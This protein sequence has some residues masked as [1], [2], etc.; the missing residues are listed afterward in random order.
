MTPIRVLIVEDS[1]FMRKMITE[2]LSNDHRIQ[3]LGTARN[4]E[5]GLKKIKLLS[6]DVVTLDVEMPI[7]D[8]I[9]TLEKIMETDP[10]PVVMLSSLTGKGAAKTIQAM[11]IGAVDFITKPS[12]SISLN[13]EEIKEEIISKVVIASQTSLK[14]VESIGNNTFKKISDQKDNTVKTVIPHRYKDTIVV[15]GTSTGG[16][17]ALQ[18]TLTALPKNFPAPIL[19][20]QHMPPNFTKSLADR[21]NT[22][23]KIDVKE[24]THGEVIQKGVAYIAP[25]DFHMCIRKVGRAFAIELTKDPQRNG[26]RP[27][28]DTLFD[29]LAQVKQVNKIAVVL[30]GMGRDG[31]MGVKKIKEDDKE[32]IAI[33]ESKD[34]SIVYGMPAAAVETECV[35]FVV[36]LNKIGITIND[37]VS[38]PGGA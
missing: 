13:I 11:S 14:K 19:I 28:V 27:A 25:G 9:T 7:M 37:L 10:L 35:N 32:A 26:H 2:I 6:P 31:A 22:L 24:A 36:H 4:G 21:L 16:P 3:V 23:S 33:A 15:I 12:G 20:V 30:T 1:A 17:R 34:S 18:Q 29:S 5:D 8:G 38:R